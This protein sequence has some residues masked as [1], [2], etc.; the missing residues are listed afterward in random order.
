[1]K[2]LEEK[3]DLERDNRAKTVKELNE[4]FADM[5]KKTK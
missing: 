2:E 1:M 5:L 3:L 4:N